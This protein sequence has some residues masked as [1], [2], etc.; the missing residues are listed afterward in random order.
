MLI[1]KLGLNTIANAVDQQGY[2]AAHRISKEAGEDLSVSN[3]GSE[4]KSGKSPFQQM[5]KQITNDGQ[6]ATSNKM[7]EVTQTEKQFS[8]KLSYQKNATLAA[9]RQSTIDMQS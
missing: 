7:R 2:Q 6:R 5:N 1:G 8:K 3:F 9:I 4:T